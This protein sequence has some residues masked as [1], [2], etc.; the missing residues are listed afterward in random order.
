ML[1]WKNLQNY[2]QFYYI[3]KL[4]IPCEMEECADM[5]FQLELVKPVSDGISNS[6]LLKR[7]CQT[8]SRFNTGLSITTPCNDLGVISN[9]NILQECLH[10]FLHARPA[11]YCSFLHYYLEQKYVYWLKTDGTT[12]LP[13]CL[14]QHVFR[15]KLYR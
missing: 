9:Q 7:H 4:N 12:Q 11:V 8:T 13:F 1:T 14:R 15:S 2:I 10:I 5:R 3:L 6:L